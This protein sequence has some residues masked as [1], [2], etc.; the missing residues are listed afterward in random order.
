[1]EVIGMPP[2]LSSFLAVAATVATAGLSASGPAAAR[3]AHSAKLAPPV[4]HESFTP[5]PC[6]GPPKHRSTLQMEGCAEHQILRSDKQI[7]TLNASIFGK[8]A[9]DAARRRFI[10]GHQ[11]WVNYRHAYCLSVSDVF[12][13]GTEA[14]VLDADCVAGVNTQHVKDLKQFLGDLHSN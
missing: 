5:L 14:G 3:P 11:A 6:T 7:D 10:S 13:G 4:M 9:D 8:L 12:Q 2:R 1:V